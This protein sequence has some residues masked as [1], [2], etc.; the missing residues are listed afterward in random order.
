MENAKRKIAIILSAVFIFIFLS[1]NLV[2][3]TQSAHECI[4][5][6]C[7]VCCVLRAAEQTLENLTTDTGTTVVAAAVV[8]GVCAVLLFTT[9][10]VFSATP[11]KLKVKITN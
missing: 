6:C 1:A 3:V 10:R 7:S 11:V 5:E 9:K 4:G 8:F 2:L